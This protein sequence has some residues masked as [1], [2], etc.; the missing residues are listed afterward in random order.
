MKKLNSNQTALGIYISPNEISIAQVNCRGNGKIHIEHLIKIPVEFE[1][2][3]R[4]QRPL[5]LNN[6][7]FNE[8]ARWINQFKQALKQVDWKSK[9][10]VITLS[11]HFSILRY[12]V[13][14]VVERRYWLKT[15]PLESKKYIPVSFDEVAYD[16]VVRPDATG[17]KLNVL[18]GMTNKKTIEFLLNLLKSL[19]MELSS[20]ESSACSIERLFY[21]LNSAHDNNAYVHF[22]GSVSYM[23]FSNAGCPVLFRESDMKGISG[24]SERKRLDIKGAQ[25]FV[26]RYLGAKAYSTLLLSGDNLEVWKS[27]A[28]VESP[29]PV[30]QWEPSKLLN[31]KSNALSSLFSIGSSLKLNSK[32]K[33]PIDF[34]GISTTA[35][36]KKNIQSHIKTVTI[37]LCAVILVFTL[38]NQLKLYVSTKRINEFYVVAGDVSEFQ[39]MTADIVKNK[40]ERFQQNSRML[41]VL[42]QD[43][44]VL[45]PKL[46]V[47]A[48][49]IP[50][51]LW[52]DEIL[53]TNLLGSLGIQSGSKEL[54]IMGSTNL[55][56]TL[57]SRFV[58]NFHKSLKLSKEFHGYGSPSGSI[59]FNM[60]SR[61][62]GDDEKNMSSGFAIYCAVK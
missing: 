34:S 5:A 44:D 46:E 16:F 49:T 48:E 27:V 32:N 54:K 53:Y 50:K 61:A 13:M 18:F 57:K 21:F 45:A 55:R 52:I 51:Y 56:G 9:K 11:S 31:L 41:Q 3:G 22:S 58:E 47:I 8:K 28:E 24:L 37:V 30:S 39:G 40:T 43:K 59:E 26:G 14:P 25:Q 17:K 6:D 19:G 2:F 33:L 35:L 4:V 42:V 1:A 36:L 38:F 7:F 15:I 29:I 60:D 10:V 23:I 20:I 62:A 12:F